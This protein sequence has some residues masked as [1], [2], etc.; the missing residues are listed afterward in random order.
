MNLLTELFIVFCNKH[1][2]EWLSADEV[3][4]QYLET[5]NPDPKIVEFL[6]TFIEMWQ[7]TQDLDIE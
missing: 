3:L 5:E 6:E 1:N 2:L 4:G 7:I